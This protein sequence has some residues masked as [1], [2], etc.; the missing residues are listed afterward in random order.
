[1]GGGF[2]VGGWYCGVGGAMRK[3]ET[4][5]REENKKLLK[6]NKETLFK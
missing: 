3:R 5:E 6:I 1:M 4:E 2:L